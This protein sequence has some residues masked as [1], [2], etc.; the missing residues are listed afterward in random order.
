MSYTALYRKF[1]P[2]TFDEVRGQDHIVRTLKNQLNSSRTGHAYLFCGT[3]GTGK[4]SIAKI[5]ARAVNCENRSDGNPCNECASCRE[6]L[7]GASMNVIEI[8]AAS[9]NG[10]ENIRQI[11]EEVRYA[12]AQG[13]YKVYIIDEAH[14]LSIGAFNA[15]L[16]TL[17]E[18]PKY[19]IFILAT[20]EPQKI[21]VTILSRCQRYDFKRITA[22]T[23]T[24]HLGSLCRLEGMTADEKALKYIAKSADGSMRDALSLLDQCIAFYPEGTLTYDNVIE[25]LGAVDTEIYGQFLRRISARDAAGCIRLLDECIMEGR[26]LKRF[27]SDFIWYLRNL[28]LLESAEDADDL[29]DASAERAASMREEA[30]LVSTGELMRFIRLFSELSNQIKF[31]SQGRVLVETALIKMCRPETESDL[32]ALESRV[33]VLERMLEGAPAGTIRS[34]AGATVGDAPEE[35]LKSTPAKEAGERTSHRE[36][37]VSAPEG[38]KSPDKAS[39]ER[40]EETADFAGKTAAPGGT[41]DSAQKTAADRVIGAWTRIYAE[42]VKELPGPVKTV[43]ELKTPAKDPANDSGVLFKMR[44]DGVWARQVERESENIQKIIFKTTGENVRIRF[45]F[46]QDKK[47]SGDELERIRGRIRFDIEEDEEDF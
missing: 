42:I 33:A 26:E 12:P 37:P 11:R 46:A 8:D 28:L 39:D 43:G 41:D 34:K 35:E 2:K 9:N 14:M 47:N 22:D 18:P 44:A 24:Q 13:Q 19:V 5:F 20:T 4:T 10:V 27:V 23:I 30:D 40:P 36:Q 29:V 1:R 16:K 3:R 32:S 25:V 21:P 6:S 15:L 7:A 31:S 17:E 38:A 45:E